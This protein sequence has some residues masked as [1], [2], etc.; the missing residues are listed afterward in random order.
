MIGGKNAP[1]NTYIVLC[2]GKFGRVNS[3]NEVGAH[4]LGTFSPLCF[5]LRLPDFLLPCSRLVGRWAARLG[6]ECFKF[7]ISILRV[8]GTLQ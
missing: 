7:R 4:P 3:F 6:I 2:H 5:A 1:Y 8:C